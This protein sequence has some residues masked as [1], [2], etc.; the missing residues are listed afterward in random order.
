MGSES[1]R[2]C[3]S[4][5]AGELLEQRVARCEQISDLGQGWFPLQGRG[6]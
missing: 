4:A 2:E 6:Q 5:R 1:V 3:V